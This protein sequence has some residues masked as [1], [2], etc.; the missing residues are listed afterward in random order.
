MH[1]VYS[2]RQVIPVTTAPSEQ[3]LRVLVVY[4]SR[5]GHTQAVAQGLARTAEADLEAIEDVRKRPRSVRHATRHVT[6]ISS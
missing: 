4:Y 1:P 2:M 3:R 6:T 5:T